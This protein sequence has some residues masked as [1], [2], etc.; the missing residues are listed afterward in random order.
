MLCEVSFHNFIFGEKSKIKQNKD[1]WL[2]SSKRGDWKLR[3]GKKKKLKVWRYF[4]IYLKSKFD[5]T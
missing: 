5:F 3:E 1:V 2:K 4:K